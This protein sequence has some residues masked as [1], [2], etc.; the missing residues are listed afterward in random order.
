MIVTNIIAVIFLVIIETTFVISADKQRL[1]LKQKV[2]RHKIQETNSSDVLGTLSDFGVVRRSLSPVMI[3]KYSIYFPKD[4]SY[5]SKNDVKLRNVIE[6]LK[7]SVILRDNILYIFS[8]LLHGLESGLTEEQYSSLQ[9]L[10]EFL[11]K[12]KIYVYNLLPILST[13]NTADKNRQTIM[14]LLLLIENLP[15]YI[16][17]TARFLANEIE[18]ER[19][20]LNKLLSKTTSE[21]FNYLVNIDLGI[22]KNK[23]KIDDDEM[24]GYD[25]YSNITQKAL[26]PV[27]VK[28]LYNLHT[29]KLPLSQELFGLILVNLP[30]PNDDPVLEE[31]IRY[32]YDLTKSNAIDHRNWDL[33]GKNPDSSDAYT[34]VFSVL[35]KILISD[36]NMVVKNAAVYVYHHL[37]VVM[38]PTY[39]NPNMMYLRHLVKHDIDIGMLLS[40]IVPHEFGPDAISL[41]NSLVMYFQYRI[42]RYKD[43]SEI[44]NGFNKF[45]YRDPLD[46]LIAYLTRL[47]N[48]I[49]SHPSI[50]LQ[51]IQESA[52]AL[53]SILIIKKSTRTFTP[54]VSP[55]IDILIL[56]ESLKIPD[57]DPTFQPTLDSIKSELIAQPQ[58]SVLVSTLL[59]TKKYNCLVPIQCL[60]S[61][62]QKIHKLR[63]NLPMSLLTNIQNILYIL[64]TRLTHQLQRYFKPQFSFY[65][66]AVETDIMR[67]YENIP[68]FN[69]SNYEI[70]ETENGQKVPNSLYESLYGWNLNNY[71]NMTSF[72]PAGLGNTRE[73]TTEK[74]KQMGNII[75]LKPT[76]TKV[77]SPTTAQAIEHL[78]P[79]KPSRE[80]LS[81]Q[82]SISSLATTSIYYDSEITDNKPSQ[83]PEKKQS[84]QLTSVTPNII[85]DQFDVGSS[86]IKEEEISPQRRTS[87]KSES[88]TY[89]IY[90]I[91]ETDKDITT[92]EPIRL[93]TTIRKIKTTSFPQ[94]MSN[95]GKLTT[96]TT[97]ILPNIELNVTEKPESNAGISHIKE[98]EIL[99]QPNTSEENESQTYSPEDVKKDVTTK[100]TQPTT[101][102][103]KTTKGETS[104]PEK[105]TN[106]VPENVT[107]I[108]LPPSIEVNEP[109]KIQLS[110]SGVPVVM[111]DDRNKTV[112]GLV[113]PQITE[114]LKPVNLNDFFS[115]DDTP[116]VTQI[117]QPLS[118]I[119]GKNYIKKILQDEDINVYST[120]IALLLA[121]LK[122]ATTYQQVTTNTN[123]MNL[124]QKYIFT[125]EYVSPTIL[126]PI[127]VS[128]KNLVSKVVYSTFSVQNLTHSA[129]SEKPPVKALPDTVT[130]PLVN[131]KIW[132]QSINPS[133]P[134]AD[135]LPTLEEENAFA[136]IIQ[137]LKNILT[138]KKVVE[139]LGPDFQPLVYPNKGTLLI[140]LLRKLRK[141]KTIQSDS[142]LKSL[143]NMYIYAIE[144]PSM[145]IQVSEDNLVKMMSETTGQW[146]P[147]LTS[148]IVALPT[149]KNI[150]ES[151]M[152]HQIEKLLVDPTVLEK[153][154]ITKPPSTMSRG[155]LLHKIILSALS[156]KTNLKKQVLK[157]FKY[158]KDK[159]EFTDMGALP[160]MWMWVETYVVKTEINLGS[161]I[162][163][164][165]NFNKLTYKEKIA[166]NDLITYLAQ[167]PNLL[168]DNEDFDFQKYKTQGQFI[169]GLFKH[170]LRKRQINNK[171]KKNIQKLFSRVILTG[172]GAIV[173]PSFS[174]F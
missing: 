119:F 34:L 96:T 153:L 102:I 99:S 66:P 45:A 131:P 161:M 173:I 56:I 55:E 113:I 168:Q 125:I 23:I 42:Y 80:N 30:N 12:K 162:Q 69:V 115:N 2:I 90:P 133:N 51:M 76:K 140:A 35:S 21:T 4:K 92:K 136:K 144:I 110:E 6:K 87:E 150:I 52:A 41:K 158:Y 3:K 130:I 93:V 103:R 149:A 64:K 116:I 8:Y 60:M 61:V 95:I 142:E 77:E 57:V 9:I 124:I 72:L 37:K 101:T 170:L 174:G 151:A 62:F 129:I 118:F 126:L 146:Q 159:V 120:N 109:L 65:L 171:I 108:I 53:L 20:N 49:P 48:H 11:K 141:T 123:L 46:L 134:Y 156:R 32:I 138:S 40:A 97:T 68:Y 86:N 160:I 63:N 85:E 145:N 157:A 94:K 44:F 122:K 165:V 164:T 154:H 88:Q 127:V 26:G 112:P 71:Y 58:L 47:V 16:Q 147:E 121:L 36:V 107:T 89:P 100:P 114:L 5:L 67:N 84:R 59:P 111:P 78:K 50:N 163:Q 155:E 14:I 43:M 17:C 38:T 139:I 83:K 75:H 166:Y 128:S 74:N 15:T 105:T 31:N 13:L 79:S 152:L 54:F 10:H 137:P 39:D 135:L 22:L 81:D 117:L 29:H 106:D 7:T 18:Q 104:I 167:N 98:E 91:K 143:I 169:K 25:K 28:L 19:L 24:K 1:E 70:R 73:Q 148:L 132:L 172:P 33:I 82:L 27:F